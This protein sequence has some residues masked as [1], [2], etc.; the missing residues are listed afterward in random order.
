M[1]FGDWHMILDDKSGE[2]RENLQNTYRLNYIR[3]VEKCL[4]S[5]RLGPVVGIVQVKMNQAVNYY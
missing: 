3:I 2:F 1:T 5:T 4:K